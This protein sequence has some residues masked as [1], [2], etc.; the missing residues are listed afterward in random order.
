MPVEPYQENLRL[1]GSTCRLL[2]VARRV[3]KYG[4]YYFTLGTRVI[5]PINRGV[6]FAALSGASIGLLV[7]RDIGL[8]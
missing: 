8:R 3:L 7:L 5:Y 2:H 1:V 6:M 4:N